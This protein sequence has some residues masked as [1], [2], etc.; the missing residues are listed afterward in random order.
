MAKFELTDQDAGRSVL[1]VLQERLPAAPQAYLRQL[2]RRGK[3]CHDGRP[4][5]EEECLQDL[6]TL[7]LPDSRRLREL[8][9]VDLPQL[10]ILLETDTCLAAFKPAGLA[11]HSCVGHATDNLTDRVRA[12]VRYRREPYQV[13]PVH[14]LDIGTSGPVLFGKG[15]RASAELGRMLQTGRIAKTYLALV[16]GSPPASGMLTT[17]V[18]VGNRIKQAASRFRVCGRHGNTALLELE[19]LSGRK[20]QIRQQCAAAGWPLYGDRR[21]GGPT[22][23]ELERLFLHCCRLSWAAAPDE[24]PLQVSS[25]LPKELCDFLR[26]RHID[27]PSYFPA[28]ADQPHVGS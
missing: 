1:A 17:G 22:A 11:V 4:L 25:P 10:T 9:A 18:K 21:Y 15:R 27:P 8:C 23:P 7:H 24:A 20:H 3:V 12:W 26:A 6:G 28:A 2:L 5:A 14:R 16:Q 19:L 13:S